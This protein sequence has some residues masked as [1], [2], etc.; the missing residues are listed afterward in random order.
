MQGMDGFVFVCGILVLFCCVIFMFCPSLTDE[1][2]FS[3]DEDDEDPL[4][5]MR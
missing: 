1:M 4:D 2:F 3:S 5:H